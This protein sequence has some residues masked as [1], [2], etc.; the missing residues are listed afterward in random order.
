MSKEPYIK[1]VSE[2]YHLSK[3]RGGGII[4]IEVWEDAAG[5]L[6]KYS[7]AYINHQ[8]FSKD[9]GR[10]LGYDNTHN[11][12]HRHFFGKMFPVENFTTYEDL[13]K[14]FEKEIEEYIK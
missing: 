4:K 3:Q 6:V 7:F 11:Y 12:H 10:V 13:L 8:L 5:N 2:R 1:T 9:N 14:R